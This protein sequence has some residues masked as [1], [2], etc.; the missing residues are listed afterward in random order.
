VV[1]TKSTS[2]LRV[3]LAGPS[4]G[5]YGGVQAVMLAIARSL[6]EEGVDVRVCFKLV[7]GT[8]VVPSFRDVLTNSGVDCI[9]TTKPTSPGFGRALRWADVV[10]V[11]TPSPDICALA[12]L[13]HRPVAVTVYNHKPDDDNNR[14]LKSRAALYLSERIWFISRFVGETWGM[15]ERAPRFE[16]APTVADLPTGAVAPQKRRGFI[17]IARLI[18]NKGLDDLVRAYGMARID[19]S[20]QPLTIVG[21]GP[22]MPVLSELAAQNGVAEHVSLAGFVDA[23]TRDSLIR[24]ARWLVAA[25]NTKED[26]GLTPIEARHVG[27]PC[28]VTRDGGL[29]EAGGGEALLCEPGDIDGLARAL[30]LASHL[31]ASEYAALSERTHRELMAY[32]RPLSWFSDRYRDMAAANGHVCRPPGPAPLPPRRRRGRPTAPL[33][34]PR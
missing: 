3:T 21:D 19:H 8:S 29:P 13:L 15:G 16:K 30:E 26:L 6:A 33:R 5:V 24:N 7:A 14:I 4:F 25:A 18:P 27:V 17:S 10:H 12:R 32:L 31:P 1:T 2:R 9:V 11:H 20:E 34:L 28:I 22:L 23:T